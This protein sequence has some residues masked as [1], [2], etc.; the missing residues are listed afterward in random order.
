VGAC[1][2]RG[3]ALAFIEVSAFFGYWRWSVSEVFLA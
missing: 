3:G 2:Q 1:R